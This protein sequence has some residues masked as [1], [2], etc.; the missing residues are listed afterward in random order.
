VTFWF[1]VSSPGSKIASALL[2][3]VFPLIT[4]SSIVNLPPVD[5]VTLPKTVTP[6]FR[7]QVLFLRH[8]HVAVG[9]RGERAGA[10]NVL[11]RARRTNRER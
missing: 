4:A 10:A 6:K 9:A 5:T 2:D 11:L 7:L 8:V 3:T 1:I